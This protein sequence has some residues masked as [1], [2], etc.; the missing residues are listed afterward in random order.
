MADKYEKYQSKHG[1]ISHKKRKQV[2]KIKTLEKMLKEIKK[3]IGDD[4]LNDPKSDEKVR[5]AIY[6]RFVEER[7]K[8]HK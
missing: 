8:N 6:S 7:P 3:A 5:K 4:L 2:K 1:K